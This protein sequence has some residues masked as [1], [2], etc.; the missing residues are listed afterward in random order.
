MNGA[1]YAMCMLVSPRKRT[2]R[3]L[4]RNAYIA[5]PDSEPPQIAAELGPGERQ[6]DGQSLA[7][8]AASSSRDALPGKLYGALPAFEPSVRW[9]PP[10]SKL[11]TCGSVS[12]GKST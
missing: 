6:V 1:D 2:W 10:P 9:S 8:C 11:V 4:L 12:W 5:F 7:P 3:H